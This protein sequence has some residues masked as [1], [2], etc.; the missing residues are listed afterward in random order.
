MQLGLVDSPAERHPLP[1]GGRGSAVVWR[2]GQDALVNELMRRRGAGKRIQAL[3]D[4]VVG[5]WLLGDQ[6]IPTRQALRALRTWS[7]PA[8]LG[9]R[10]V[11]RQFARELLDGFPPRLHAALFERLASALEHGRPL[12]VGD[13]ELPVERSPNV[14]DRAVALAALWNP[15]VARIEEQVGEV[16][17]NSRARGKPKEGELVMRRLQRESDKAVAAATREWEQVVAANGG[18]PPDEV[19]NVSPDI[20]RLINNVRRL[21]VGIAILDAVDVEMLERVRAEV[22]GGCR[23][24]LVALGG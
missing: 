12:D 15:E 9:S 1:G 23:H 11:S 6:T 3:A 5:R 7:R 2:D 14:H 18:R 17:R 4:F 21:T 22:S 16:D 24:L 8:R 10:R 19:V 20:V 13:L